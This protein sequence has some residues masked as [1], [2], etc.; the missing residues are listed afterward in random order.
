MGGVLAAADATADLVQLGQPE[1]VRAL[2]DERVDLRDVEPALDDRGRDEHVEVA[3]QELDHRLLE[4][5]VVHLAV[6]HADA[7]LRHEPAQ[8]LGRLVDRL[9]AVVQVEDLAVA[10]R[11]RA[12][13]PPPRASRRTRS[14]ACGSAGGRA[15]ASRSPR[16]RAAPPATCAACAGSASP[17]SRARRPRAA[18][19]AAAPSG[20]RRSAAPRRRR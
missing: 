13:P 9:D 5:L 11:A 2:D 20:A 19:G 12:A 7:R 4:L 18:A 16:C 14:R 3:A 10:R 15:A 17:T 6:P 1:H 8:L